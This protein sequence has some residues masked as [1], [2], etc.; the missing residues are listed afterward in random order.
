MKKCYLYFSKSLLFFLLF[1]LIFPQVQAV[2]DENLN[3]SRI[4]FISSYSP[5]FP[6]F[7]LQIEGLRSV[8]DETKVE[9]KIEYMDTKNFPSKENTLRFYES[10]KY[11]LN[12]LDP[13]DVVVV[14]DDNALQFAI[15]YQQELFSETPIVF[16]GINDLDRAKLAGANDLMTGVVEY[17]SMEKTIELAMALM[18]NATEII[19]LGDS[20]ET[21]VAELQIFNNVVKDIENIESR[22]L[23]VGDYTFE[24]MAIE[25]QNIS[26]NTIVL[27]LS[28]YQDKT[29]RVITY[30]EVYRFTT[31]NASFPIFRIYSEGIGE[32]FLGGKVVNHFEQGKSAGIMVQDILDGQDVSGIPILEVSPNVYMFDHNIIEKFNINI[33]LLPE[34]A[35]IINRKIGFYD[36]YT[37]LF[38]ISLSIFI[39]L[40]AIIVIM[41]INTRR[42]KK[43]ERELLESN[44]QLTALY[45]ELEAS[46]EEL[47]HQF[48]IIQE[49]NEKLEVSKERYKY[50]FL[51]SNE[52]LW[53]IDVE[54]KQVYLSKE[55]YK[56]FFGSEFNSENIS[57]KDWMDII[58]PEDIHIVKRMVD[59]IQASYTKKISCEYRVLDINKNIVWVQQSSISFYNN[60][61]K[62]TRVIGSHSNITSRK[63]QEINI[64]RLAYNDTLTG[65]PNRLALQNK[66]IS[67]IQKENQRAC[68]ALMFLDVDNFKYVND[69]YGHIIGDKVLMEIG[70]R[71]QTIK[72][73]NISIYRFGGDEFIILINKEKDIDAIKSIAAKIIDLFQHKYSINQQRFYLTT[74]IGIVMY[75]NDGTDP[76]NLIK[77]ADSAMYKAK[78]KGKNQ[79]MFFNKSMNQ[80]IYD[81]MYIHNNLRTALEENQFQLHYQPQIDSKSK[82]VIGFEALI[83]WETEEFGFI[84]PLKFIKIAEESDM[85]IKIGNW[86]LKEAAKFSKEIN[87]YN[88]DNYIVSVNVSSVQLKQDNFVETVKKIIKEAGALPKNM[89]IEIT[90]TSLM[91]NFESNANKVKK[92]RE[93]GIKVALDDFGTGY[94]SLNY[95]RQLPINILKLDKS[96]IEDLLK[97]NNIYNLT[98]DIILMSQKLG[99]T[100]V[101][102]GVEMKDQFDLLSN[103][104]CDIIQGY[105]VSRPIPK[106]EAVKF[107]GPEVEFLI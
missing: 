6:T 48:E 12:I 74:S 3:P 65:L 77:D 71:L 88:K 5:S 10:M 60:R 75:P 44:E 58:Y 25:I 45:E 31:A 27:L 41:F 42:R 97:N 95:L 86:I 91:D 40:V 59:Q 21:G 94:S 23:N 20:T 93:L 90:E 64:K 81:R 92:L 51:A 96:F 67:I 84:P 68:G 4:L 26:P 100:V 105:L 36:Q 106:E 55:W 22:V 2:A 101:A 50:V 34:D 33:S 83:R 89:G 103:Y 107:I 11:K 19:A 1:F 80:E 98:E 99:L 102:E 9:F 85:I 15:D 52:G 16:L 13:F 79:Y 87:Q 38:W 63:N 53:D 76:N 70:N 54:K 35:V 29:G 73:E 47:R 72:S 104:N 39:F 32:G 43:A 14:A 61:G 62:L 56:T 46:D 18:P 8:L 28:F 30:N 82:K 49:S 37:L 24:E 69:T 66:L 17:V 78:D 57:I 7:D